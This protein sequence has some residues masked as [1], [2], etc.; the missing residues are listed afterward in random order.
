MTQKVLV[1]R[2]TN[3]TT[4]QPTIDYI[5]IYVYIYTI[6]DYILSSLDKPVCITYR[7]NN[8]LGKDRYPTL[9]L[10]FTVK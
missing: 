10:P 2:K 3:Q 5:Y 9:L 6:M 8:I 4:K 7:T 1:H